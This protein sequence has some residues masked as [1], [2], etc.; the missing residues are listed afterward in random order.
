MIFDPKDKIVLKDQSFDITCII[1]LRDGGRK[2]QRMDL[3]IWG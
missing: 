2:L 1:K 3:Y